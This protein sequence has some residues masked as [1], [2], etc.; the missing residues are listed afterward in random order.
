MGVTDKAK[1]PLNYC[2]LFYI[3][4]EAEWGRVLPFGAHADAGAG[5]TINNCHIAND[6]AAAVVVVSVVTRVVV[7]VVSESSIVI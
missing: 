5:I 2:K 1:N 3:F 7:V 6:T 4:L